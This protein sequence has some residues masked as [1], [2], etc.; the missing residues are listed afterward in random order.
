MEPGQRH[1][2]GENRESFCKGALRIDSQFQL[3]TVVVCGNGQCFIWNDWNLGLVHNSGQCRFHLLGYFS[4]LDGGNIPAYGLGNVIGIGNGVAFPEVALGK[5]LDSVIL[6][7][8]PYCPAQSFPSVHG[9]D[10]RHIGILDHGEGD[11]ACTVHRIVTLHIQIGCIHFGTTDD[12]VDPGI[13]HGND[14][15]TLGLP[16]GLPLLVTLVLLRNKV[17]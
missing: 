9:A 15:V 5:N 13:L 3:V 17:K 6:L 7:N 4:N 16:L 11:V 1:L 12:I 14:V 2:C 10:L 8:V